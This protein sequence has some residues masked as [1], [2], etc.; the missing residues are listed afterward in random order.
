MCLPPV[1]GGFV[2]EITGPNGAG[3]TTLFNVILGLINQDEGT[4]LLNGASIDGLR[5][6]QRA[7]LGIGCLWQ[8]GRI[9]RNLSVLDNLLVA[10]LDL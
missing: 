9:F 1:V 7:R 3:K 6:W 2:V 4:V 8:D 5:P 10:G